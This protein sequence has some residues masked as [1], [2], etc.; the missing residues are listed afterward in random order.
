M[1]LN[2]AACLVVGAS[3]HDHIHQSCTRDVLVPQRIQFKIAA[4]AFD[5]IVTPVQLTSKT[6][7]VQWS[8]PPVEQTSVQLIA[9][10]CL[11]HEK[12]ACCCSNS[13]EHSSSS[14]GVSL[15]PD[16]KTADKTA[17]IISDGRASCTPTPF[18]FPMYA[19]RSSWLTYVRILSYKNG[20]TIP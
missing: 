8:T 2:A 20:V 16:R 13:V 10:T 15:K 17:K 7:A 11:S 12:L 4:T 3:R 19:C 18:I 14:F 1:A 6:S 5:C 9:V